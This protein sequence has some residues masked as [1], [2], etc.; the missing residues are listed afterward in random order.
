MFFIKKHTGAMIDMHCHIIPGVDDGSRDIEQSINMIKIAHEQGIE[1]MILT[2]HYKEGR[3][4]ASVD[5]IHKKIDEL[6][7]EAGKQG[8]VIDMLPGNEVYYFQEIEEKL[9]SGEVLTLN[10]TDR[11]LVEFSPTDQYRYI[12][13]GLDNVRASG[14]TPIIAHVERY[15]SMVKDWH[16]VDE[17]K[18]MGVEIQ[19]NAPS[20]IGTIGKDIQK[21]TNVLLKEQL[22]DYVGTDAHDDVKRIPAFQ[23]AYRYIS[24][25]VGKQYL[26]DIFYNNAKAI[27]E[28]E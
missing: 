24:K 14:Y 6:K 23:E 21:F 18:G 16:R 1:A 5:T 7:V 20:T 12:R 27:I 11:V 9:E 17:I 19:I 22:V 25:K 15:E 10:G 3:H 13:N 4:N 28:A 2:P 26:E 8:I